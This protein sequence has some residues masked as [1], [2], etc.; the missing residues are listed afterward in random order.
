MGTGRCI[1]SMRFGSERRVGRPLTAFVPLREFVLRCLEGG[2]SGREAVTFLVLPRKVTKR[3]RADEGARC[4]GALCCSSRARPRPRLRCSAPSTAGTST[5][6]PSP[7]P[8]PPRGGEGST[9]PSPAGAG[10]GGGEGG[11]IR[12]AVEAAEQ[13][14]AGR[15]PRGS[16]S[17]SVARHR[18]AIARVHDPRRTDRAAQGSRRRRPASSARLWLRPL[19]AAR[20]TPAAPA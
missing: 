16:L 3:R 7:S 6:A 9:S 4:A 17:E 18:R 14:R 15:G 5:D 1:T 12:F 10:E 8:S 13:R 11:S 20:F 19:A 2:R